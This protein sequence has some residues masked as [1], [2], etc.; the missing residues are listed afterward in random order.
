MTGTIIVLIILRIQIYLHPYKDEQ[1]NKIEIQ[2]TL[3][4]MFTLFCG[5]I[6]IEKE[7]TIKHF[8]IFMAILMF[9]FNLSFIMSWTYLFI[10]SWNIKNVTFNKIL[11][12]FGMLLCKK[13]NLTI[14]LNI[15]SDKKSELYYFVFY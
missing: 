12:L 4:G 11:S 5:I 15:D 14:S 9:M 10:V 1:N 6:F 3:A 2:G 13:T 8:N 7:D